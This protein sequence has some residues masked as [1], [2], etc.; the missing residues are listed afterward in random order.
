VV[1]VEENA[2][3]GGFGAACLEA[4]EARGLLEGGLA[5]RR[6]GIPDR[7]ITHADQG[8]QRVEVGIDAPAIA[9]AA[10]ALCG[11]KPARGVA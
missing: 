4:F 5:V 7:F 9:R 2:L 8:H 3:A 11:A 6:L 10:R 1:T